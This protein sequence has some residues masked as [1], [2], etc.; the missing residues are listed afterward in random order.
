MFLIVQQYCHCN[1]YTTICINQL[2][3]TRMAPQINFHN[4]RVT[5]IDCDMN[6]FYIMISLWIIAII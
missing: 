3:L 6:L 2:V 5:I 1:I 4:T